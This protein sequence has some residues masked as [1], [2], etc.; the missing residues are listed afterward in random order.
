MDTEMFYLPDRMRGPLA[1][2]HERRA[3][4]VCAQCPVVLECRQWAL[5]VDDN[6]AVLGGL[7]PDQRH[8]LRRRRQVG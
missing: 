6:W 3:L 5:S 7:T 8:E 4:N 1:R 2:Q